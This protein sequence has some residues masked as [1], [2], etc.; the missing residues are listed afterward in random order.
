MMVRSLMW[1][2]HYRPKILLKH[3]GLNANGHIRIL[4]KTMKAEELKRIANKVNDDKAAARA[5]AE[6][7]QHD[8]IIDA[9][10]KICA[11]A[12]NRGEYHA[13]V[14]YCNNE[15]IKI[16]NTP[17]LLIQRVLGTL[18]AK[19]LNPKLQY[20]EH[21]INNAR[22]LPKNWTDT[23]KIETKREYFIKVSW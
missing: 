17:S 16:T 5:E 20:N 6:K 23:R 21:R 22:N 9:A 11:S 14:Y 8:K 7:R 19:G 1:A 15:D 4:S 12:A 18:S 13:V 2:G 10:I 3:M